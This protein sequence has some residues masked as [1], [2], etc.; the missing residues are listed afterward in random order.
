MEN[1]QEHK[2]DKIFKKSLDIQPV[3]PPVD[4][5]TGIHTYTIGQEKT[6]RKIGL[7][8]VSLSMLFLLF[9]GFGLWYYFD[10]QAIIN[11]NNPKL[12]S[13]KLL[14]KNS[15]NEM[16]NAV[17]VQNPDS[18]EKKTSLV[19]SF[20]PIK[21]LSD[22][23]SQYS[24]QTTVQKLSAET[25]TA[26]ENIG[27]IHESINLNSDS[28]DLRI[29]G[30]KADM[31]IQKSINLTGSTSRNPNSDSNQPIELSS[32]NYISID[33]SKKMED[34]LLSK[35]DDNY[36]EEKLIQKD[37][38]ME[39]TGGKRFS[40]KHPIISLGY[41]VSLNN[42]N[43]KR[44]I[45][46]NDW[47]RLDNTYSG[48]PIRLGHILNL[49]ISWKLTPRF[50]SGINISYGSIDLGYSPSFQ[51]PDSSKTKYSSDYALRNK[52]KTSYQIRTTFG[53]IELPAG[54][55]ESKLNFPQQGKLDSSRVQLLFG[56]HSMKVV[57]LS[58]NN[59]YDFIRKQRKKGKKYTYQM[60][61]LMDLSIQKQIRYSFQALSVFAAASSTFYLGDVVIRKDEEHLQNAS[62]FIFGLRTGLGF[63]YQFARK[64]DFYLEGSGQHSLNNW[65]K[66]DD[67]KTFQ[68]SISLQV[69]I[70]LN[71]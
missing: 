69:G 33:L 55:L 12:I 49:G 62:E 8:Y 44:D 40:L 31:Q 7:R 17:R 63:R 20:H 46:M 41:N 29:D 27:K 30:L 28:L 65:V 70:N 5:W 11:V 3:T 39:E 52:D 26:V 68:R 47:V 61:G 22:Y 57:A 66:S 16:E 71:L 18:V 67:I 1:N 64:W 37:S 19:D 10:N 48:E 23:A 34:D 2:I 38:V 32:K 58:I 25:T 43:I 13:Q 51:V 35:I 56:P 42:W 24:P 50:R 15:N 9:F 53:E 54:V 59:Q 45:G 36:L 21:P 60:Y 4:A 6:E 14:V